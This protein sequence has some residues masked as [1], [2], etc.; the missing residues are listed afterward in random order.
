M[1]PRRSPKR[2]AR[3][4]PLW[5]AA[6]GLA[7][8]L[9]ACAPGADP[10]LDFHRGLNALDDGRYDWA[11]VCFARDLERHP[12][13]AA[14]WRLAATAWTA[15]ANGSLSR[16]LASYRGYL[17]RVPGDR[18]VR[19]RAARL[20]LQLGDRQEAAAQAAQL[21]DGPEVQLLRAELA[22]DDDPARAR[23]AL[24]AG[25]AE[26]PD[27]A[28]LHVLAARLEER[29]GAPQQALAEAERAVEL[30]PLD[31]RSYYLLGRL[32]RALGDESRA[33]EALAVQQLAARF[34]VDGSQRPPST[35]EALR[36]LDELAPKVASTAPSFRLARLRLLAAAGRRQEAAAEADALAALGPPA[37]ADGLELARLAEQA[38]AD[39]LARRLYS[40]LA[41]A[42]PA[43]DAPTGETPTDQTRADDD[44]V[45]RGAVFGLAR[46]AWKEADRAGC[47][48]LLAA[49]LARWPY[50]ARFHQLL[51]SLE[52]AEDRREEA[53]A[54][55]GRT[56]ELAPWRD[57]ARTD[58]ADLYLAQDRR[59]AA[60]EL[61]AAAPEE[62]PALTR[63]RRRH[64]LP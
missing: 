32:W 49:G 61:L 19:L 7:A 34:A 45:A 58:L 48:R 53:A 11:R 57:A 24:A 56:L 5:G 33:A 2:H 36:L 63:Y 28:R 25:L 21:G 40:A 12:E 31:F 29:S 42:T 26:A 51:A 4:L 64:G 39:A 10:D 35:L 22:L 27:D 18:Q 6:F 59:R 44:A 17:R 43:G 62:S 60:V 1:S 15:G 14:S 23:Q 41:A 16:A 47:R 8:L 37:G 38:G 46:L 50:A 20:L 30:A 52:L 54:E 13:R 3:R 55:L 9:A